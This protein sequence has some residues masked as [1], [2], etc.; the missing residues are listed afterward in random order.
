VTSG[1]A[2]RDEGTSTFPPGSPP[3]LLFE[4]RRVDGEE[5]KQ[6]QLEQTRAIREVV[7]WV[8]RMRSEPGQNKAA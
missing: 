2:E 7:Q 4:F 1:D 3:R 5:A 8:A 6:L